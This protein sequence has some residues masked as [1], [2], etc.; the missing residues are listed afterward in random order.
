[1]TDKDLYIKN[2]VS[3]FPVHSKKEKKYLKN[4][5]NNINEF[6]E[7]YPLS[8]YD[9]FVEKFGT[10]K[11][12]FVDYISNQDEYY[13]IKKLNAKKMIKILL[14]CILILTISLEL[15]KAFLLY[16]DR[17]ESA[18]QEIRIEIEI[19]NLP[20]ELKGDDHIEK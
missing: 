18:N 14:I 20:S 10:P 4:L 16:K 6:D 11:E 3:I 13:L 15:W 1:M 17:E 8:S 19:P 12:V 7:D 9:G 2:V 5:K